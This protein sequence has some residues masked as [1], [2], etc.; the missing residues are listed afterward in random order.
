VEGSYPVNITGT[1]RAY[2]AA[3]ASQSVAYVV[4]RGVNAAVPLPG[5]IE[6]ENYNLGGEGVA[7]H[8]LTGVGN[9][10]G[11]YRPNEAVGIT[12]ANDT[13]GGYLVGWTQAG[14]WLAYAVKVATNGTYTLTVRVASQGPGGRFHIEFDG[15]D[16]TG[17][18]T[19]PDTG[20]WY[21]WQTI[22]K[23]G[24]RLTAGTYTMKFVMD[25]VA[26]APWG[27]NLNWFNFTK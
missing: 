8:D 3:Q 23:T 20:G 14:E 27:G 13:D 2:A 26:V 24:V 9:E 18:M 5:K 1:N 22:T 7:Y 4:G 11:L 25:S 6:A 15:V 19:V 21:N 12:T 16:K 10:G 17:P